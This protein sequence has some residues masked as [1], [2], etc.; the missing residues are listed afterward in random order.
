[1]RVP[2]ISTYYAATFRLGNL[3]EDLKNANE[4]IST[5]KRINEISDDPLGLSQVLSLRNSIGNLEQIE[6]NVIMGKSWLEGVEASLDSVNNLILDAKSEVSRLTNDSTTADERQNAVARID[7]IINQIVSLGNTQ[8]NDSYIFGGTRTDVIPLEYDTSV[9]PNRVLY[10]GN[11]TPFEIR[12]DRN[13]GVQVGRNGKTTFWDDTI[14]IN[15]TNNKV[16]FTEDNGHGSASEKVLTATI[17]DG[18]YTAQSLETAVRNGLNQASEENGYGAGYLVSYDADA[19]K[20]DIREDGSYGGYLKTQFLW[21]TGNQ[22]HI[23]D[24]TASSTIDPD[25]INISTNPAALTIGT[26]EPHGTEPFTLVWQK[27]DTWKVV[28]NPGYVLSSSMISGTP[29]RIDIDLNE[30]GTPDISIKLDAPVNHK[31]D[32]ISFEI[33]PAGEDD[34]IGHEIGFNDRDLIHAPPV[35]DTPARFITDLVFEDGSNDE[36]FFQEVNSTGGTS[37][38]SIDLNTTG[39]DVTYVDMQA[40][41]GDI[42]AKMEAAS[43]AGPN[44]IEYNVSYD[45]GTSRFNIREKG[46]DLDELYLQWDVGNSAAATLGFYGAPDATIYPASDLA[47]NRTIVLDDTNNTFSF[48]ETGVLGTAGTAITATVAQGTYRNATSFAAAIEAA[49]DTASGYAP[50]AYDVTYDSGTNRFNIQDTGANLSEF[51]LLWKTGGPASDYLAKSLGQSPVVDYTGRLSYDSNTDPVIMTFDQENNWIDFSETDQNGNTITAGIQIPEGD[52]TNPNHLAALIQTEMRAASYNGVDYAVS[53][54]AVE[55]EFVFK[56]GG[57]ADIA[58]FRLLWHSGEHANESAAD[59]LGFAGTHDDRAIFSISDEPVVNLT[60]NGSNNKIDFMEVS[61]SNSGKTAGY[62]TASVAEKTYTSH[63]DLAGEIEKALEAESHI[64]GNKIDYTVAWDDVTKKYTIKENGS[65]LEAFHLQWRTG[66]NAPAAVGGSGESIGEILGFDPVSDDVHTPI[67]STRD[68]EWGIFNT[69]LDLKQYLSDNDRDGI[70]RTLGR[71]E[72]DFDNMTSKIVDTGMKY[73]RL[74]IRETITRDVGL[75]L[76]QRRSM[77]EDAD[78][79]EA[80]MNL[81]SIQTA[82]QAALASTSQ[83]LNISLVDYLR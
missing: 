2:N 56:E 29:D 73:T 8:V 7:H 59:Q 45:P 61:G 43:A 6:K 81:Q 9:D 65:D 51:S 26:P 60:I 66:D 31:G 82:Y 76:D 57:N 78:I 17:L 52:Y 12:T 37:T 11:E 1:M 67:K 64:K 49:L 13:S 79:I 62:L 47:L 77:I 23:N 32:F 30:S 53:Y 16:V 44:Q 3:T 75:S 5:Q 41:A 22:A 63:A 34:S 4:V 18:K 71:L 50:P 46:T 28:N 25:D 36:V 24:I 33:I 42:K 39:V 15:A 27:N 38:F 35:S 58:S 69:L 20:F 55:Q 80:I 70:E 40:L 10:K 19:K 83:V 72:A 74:E 54:D 68:V 14:T 48:Q 21:E